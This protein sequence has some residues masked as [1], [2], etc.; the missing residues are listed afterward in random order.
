ML[1]KVCLNRFFEFFIAIDLRLD[2]FVS[3]PP[4]ARPP[5]LRKG[6]VLIFFL[7]YIVVESI[8]PNNRSWK[9]IKPIFENCLSWKTLKHEKFLHALPPYPHILG[10][11]LKK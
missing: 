6:F 8:M 3:F 1:Y 5:S 2:E 10:E 11:N 4:E 7:F 9:W